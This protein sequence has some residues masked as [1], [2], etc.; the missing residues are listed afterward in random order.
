MRLTG[1]ATVAL[2][3]GLL[4]PAAHA[5]AVA[6]PHCTADVKAD[7]YI[8]DAAAFQH[9]LASASTV[10]IDTARMD[11]FGNKQM[12]SLVQS[13]GKQVVDKEGRADLIFDLSA[14]DRNGSINVGPTDIATATLSVYDPS[15]GAGRRGLVWVETFD[16]GADRPWPSV[17]V[18]LIRQFKANA[19]KQ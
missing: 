14:I 12:T 17:I 16:N 3:A 7:Y 11:L 10:R 4:L 9:R 6:E 18:D 1:F 15:K 2:L 19:L 8:C 13:L 5:Q